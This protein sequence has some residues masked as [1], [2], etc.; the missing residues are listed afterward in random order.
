MTSVGHSRSVSVPTLPSAFNSI[1]STQV[2]P[3]R[4]QTEDRPQYSAQP[5]IQD[6]TTRQ[7]SLGDQIQ[8]LRIKT[9]STPPRESRAA[10]R[11]LQQQHLG[12]VDRPGSP[13]AIAS[14]SPIESKPQLK[15]ESPASN[16]QNLPD[17]LLADT[18]HSSPDSYAPSHALL[19]IS[20]TSLPL[21][22]PGSPSLLV[23]KMFV[24]S[25]YGDCA[26]A[27][28]RSEHLARHVRYVKASTL[29]CP[30]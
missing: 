14:N 8:A 9:P 10:H 12:T 13:L 5:P 27:F 15:A 29:R 21:E 20:S 25:G 3:T 18:Y 22:V 17:Q 16:R 2:V 30:V 1:D 4:Y 26:M 6:T 24:C 28:S 19:E 11:L 7:A 23:K